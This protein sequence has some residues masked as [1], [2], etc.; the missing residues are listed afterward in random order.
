MEIKDRADFLAKYGK[1]VAV[2]LGNV[3]TADYELVD[4][5]A[6]PLD[7]ETQADYTRR[8]LGYVATFALLDGQFRQAYAVQL[9]VEVI[10]GLAESYASLVLYRI[11]NPLKPSGDGAEWLSR[12]YELPDHR[13]E[14]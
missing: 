10:V 6:C 11:A 7:A 2:A 4:L 3:T 12:L 5:D 13:T 8:G 14:N 9:P 1:T